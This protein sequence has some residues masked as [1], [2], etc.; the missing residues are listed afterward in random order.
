MTCAFTGHR[1]IKAEHKKMLPDLLNRAIS[2]A[3]DRGC[4]RFIAGG[5]VGFD[6]EAARAVLRFRIR[7]PDVSLVLY[8]PCINQDE[9]WNDRQKDAY[10]FTLSVADEVVYVSDEYSRSC[11]KRRNQA[12]AD[13]CDIMIGYVGHGRSGSLQTLRLAKSAGKPCYNLYF[14]LEKSSCIENTITKQP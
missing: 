3:Y 1:Q 11:M 12:L 5:A 10:S 9:M 8:L 13:A 2:Y 7:H 14:E 6:T 4:R